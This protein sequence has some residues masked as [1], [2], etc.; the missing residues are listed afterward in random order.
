[1]YYSSS[2]NCNRTE[3]DKFGYSMPNPS[4]PQYIN[5]PSMITR[6]SYVNSIIYSHLDTQD[7]HIIYDNYIRNLFL[8]IRSN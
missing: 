2:V 6:P 5:I 3:C 8:N 7:Q 1:M 4:H